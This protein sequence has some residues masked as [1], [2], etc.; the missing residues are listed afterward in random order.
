[1]KRFLFIAA[2]VAL[3]A[4]AFAEDQVLFGDVIK[5]SGGFGAPVFGAT[6]IG[7]EWGF[8]SGGRGAWVVN[9]KCCFGG[10]GYSVDVALE[11]GNENDVEP[12]LD[13]GMGGFEF[14]YV[15]FSDKVVHF[16][17]GALVGAGGVTFQDLPRDVETTDM[18]FVGK[19][20]AS[21]ELNLVKW[22]RLDL[23]GGYRYVTGVDADKFASYGRDFDDQD[24]CGPDAYVTVKFGK[25]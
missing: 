9:H 3:A 17:V 15:A 6:A 8:F 22:L 24:F 7:G 2:A 18:V 16:T 10:G 12:R 20:A 19:P 14:E 13:L 11:P 1:M 5:D 21:V 25:F 23:G 4:S